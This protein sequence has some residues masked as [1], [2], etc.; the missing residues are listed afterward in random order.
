MNKILGCVVIVATACLAAC[1]FQRTTNVLAPSTGGS[2]GTTA[3]SYTGTWSSSFALPAASS[4]GNF[5][6]NITS[7]TATSVAGTFSATCGGGIAITGQASGQLV[8][9]TTVPINVKG[10]AV[11]VPGVGTCDFTLS[12]TGTV[13][14]NGT[15]L[16]IPYT[17]NTCLGPVHGTE[18]LHKAAPAPAPAPPSVP[19]VPSAPSG[20]SDAIDLTQAAVYNSPPDIAN[21]PITGAITNIQFAQGTTGLS[22]QF[23]QQN[24]WP[25]YT[26][27]GWN[28]PLEYTVWAVVKISGRWDTAGFIQ[29]WRGRPGTGAGIVVNNDFSRNWAYDSRWGPMAGYQPQVGEQIGFFLS[30]GD[31]RGATTVTS[32]RERTNVV[33]VSLP[34]GDNGSFSFSLARLPFSNGR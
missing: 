12:G 27:P 3:A 4:C 30:A 31:A 15:A 23:A 34:A 8:N 13:Q 28:G 2:S 26:P 19:T 5:Q 1:G 7:Q 25:D 6:W 18:V 29:M 17:G 14:D 24:S 16:N 20:P 10:T 11:G 22:F 33:V 21:W 32:L 9:S